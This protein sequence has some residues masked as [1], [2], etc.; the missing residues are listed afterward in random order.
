M[1][2]IFKGI[3]ASLA[4]F[5]MTA[6]AFAATFSDVEGTAY[7]WANAYVED[8]ANNPTPEEEVSNQIVK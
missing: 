2:K 7:D 1:N 6:T 3:I 5:S 4:A 8:M